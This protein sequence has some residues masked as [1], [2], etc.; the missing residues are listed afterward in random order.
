M[1]AQEN[2][3]KEHEP[4]KL[5][6]DLHCHSY[7]S[8]DG[9]A[10]PIDMVRMAKKKGLHGFVITDHDTSECADFFLEHELM[11]EDGLPVDGFLIIPGQEISTSAGHLLAIGVS[12][13][14]MKGIAPDEAVKLVH[15]KGGLAIPAH[16][17]DTFRS[18]ICERWLDQLEVDGLEVFN[19]ATV[20]KKYNRQAF[21]YA[22]KRRLP[23]TAGSDAHHAA[24]IGCAYTIL[25]PRE[26]TRAAVIESIRAPL[27]RHERY[28]TLR[29]QSIKTWH[30]VR[31]KLAQRRRAY[32]H[33]H[34]AK[35]SLHR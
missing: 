33:D 21:D 22:Q 35:I 24:A 17:Y 25:T 7:F 14:N 11:R 31:K 28:M 19:A 26:L 27:G 6:F 4:L 9:V 23:M 2:I 18:G 34:L 8:H 30:L 5:C 1:N 15:A 20:L 16:P 3:L 29:D 13:P 12:L 32:N 10:N